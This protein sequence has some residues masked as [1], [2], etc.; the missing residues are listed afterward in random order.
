MS[1]G[2]CLTNTHTQTNR[3]AN[4]H[5]LTHVRTNLARLFDEITI[6]LTLA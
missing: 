4:T 5:T 3:H 2:A 6:C 1:M